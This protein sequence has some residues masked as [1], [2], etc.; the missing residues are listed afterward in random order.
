MSKVRFNIEGTDGFTFA[1]RMIKLAW[2]KAQVS[3]L[4]FLQDRGPGISEDQVWQNALHRG[5]YPGG[6]LG[7][8][9]EGDASADYVFGRMMKLHFAFGPDFVEG[10]NS[11]Y[12]ADYQSFCWSFPNFEALALAAAESLGVKAA[13]GP[14][15]R[16]YQVFSKKADHTGTS[17]RSLQV[18]EGAD[19]YGNSVLRDVHYDEA[20]KYVEQ[21]GRDFDRYQ[22]MSDDNRTP[23]CNLSVKECR[24]QTF[25]MEQGSQGRGPWATYVSPAERQVSGFVASTEKFLNDEGAEGRG[26]RSADAVAAEKARNA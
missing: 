8:Q 17:W 26:P 19:R 22:E 6:N 5:D 11:A 14:I 4:G 10:D 25:L 3:G 20:R 9:H 2:D 16:V 23:Y 21:H 12:R 15:P 7:K 18:K 24:E 1:K 13:Q